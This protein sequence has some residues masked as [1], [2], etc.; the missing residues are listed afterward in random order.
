MQTSA[1]KAVGQMTAFCLTDR[2]TNTV[3]NLIRICQEFQ[4]DPSN[5]TGKM[6][7]EAFCVPMVLDDNRWKLDVIAQMLEERQDL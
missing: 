4:L 2:R 3:K 5:V 1:I 6:V 7:R